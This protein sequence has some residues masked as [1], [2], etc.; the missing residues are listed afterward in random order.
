MTAPIPTGR[1]PVQRALDGDFCL[2]DAIAELGTSTATDAR[3]M[4]G[5]PPALL[6]AN[7]WR[8]PFAPP[9]AIGAGDSGGPML[10][11]DDDARLLHAVETSALWRPPVAASVAGLTPPEALTWLHLAE[12]WIAVDA[13]SDDHRY[14][15]TACKLFGA[16]WTRYSTDT[17]WR[18]PQLTTQAARVA[19]LLQQA[20]QR[21]TDQLANRRHPTD[22]PQN[23]PWI[24]SRPAAGRRGGRVVVLHG[25]GSA[26]A[27]RLLHLAGQ[28]GVPI[29][30]VFSFTPEH[31]P[32]PAAEESAYAS[33]WYPP[34]TPTDLA[35]PQPEAVK[36]VEVRGWAATERAL[37]E[38]GADVVVL[39]GMP[40]VP[41]HVL[42][43]ARIGFVNAHNGSLPGYRGMDAVAWALINAG[44]ITCTLHIAATQV[45]AGAVLASADVPAAP[46]ATLKDR[47]KQTQLQLLLHAAQ[48]VTTTGTLPPAAPQ[49]TGGARQ[50]YR[51][52]PHL[53]R[54]LDRSPYTAIQ[55]RPA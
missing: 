41:E 32:G 20:T 30:H 43:T 8:L 1:F 11:T 44:P 16:T 52:H 45:D 39:V 49:P 7:A 37:A 15:N 29:A 18:Q 42:T 17:A 47:V 3:A 33:A 14:L 26:G 12:H 27:T 21:L 40:I 6:A 55:G 23:R 34:S 9:P 2:T 25:H 50:F 10:P 51:L 13:A 38:A 48:H 36:T 54:I 46:A 31:D 19:Y 5:L 28:H 22:E 24:G 35:A 53:K 4:P